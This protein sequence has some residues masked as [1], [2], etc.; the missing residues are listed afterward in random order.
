MN[1][2]KK[3]K[4]NIDLSH[5]YSKGPKHFGKVVYDL[6]KKLGGSKS[7]I[8]VDL[9]LNWDKIVG[10]EIANVSRIE[11]VQYIKNNAALLI[12]KTLFSSAAPIIQ[13][14]SANI[15]ERVNTYFGCN[16]IKEIKIKH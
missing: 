6:A 16:L 9:K 8:E 3:N 11:K 4:K 7:F 13:L 1:D 2:T 12:I 5:R 10:D 15:I 14:K